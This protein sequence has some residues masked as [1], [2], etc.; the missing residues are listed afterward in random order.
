MKH[1]PIVAFL[2]LAVMAISLPNDLWAQTSTTDPTTKWY[3]A[4]ERNS[5]MATREGTLQSTPPE[6][7]DIDL[8]FDPYG[9]KDTFEDSDA[10]I[11]TNQVSFNHALGGDIPGG[12]YEVVLNLATA[13]E[14]RGKNAFEVV[15][16]LDK[17]DTSIEIGRTVVTGASITQRQF[18]LRIIGIDPEAEKGDRLKLV[19]ENLSA[20]GGTLRYGSGDGYLSYIKSPW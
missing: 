1:K 17:K 4:G 7:Y 2:A 13:K 18:T 15:I 19:I 16:V 11:S 9:K 6:G 12:L 10:S 3:L 20:Y 14:E 5:V 8:S